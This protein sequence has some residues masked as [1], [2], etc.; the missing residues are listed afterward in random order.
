[1]QFTKHKSLILL[2]SLFIS[3]VYMRAQ[4]VSE[5][6]ASEQGAASAEASGTSDREWAKRTSKINVY[7][8]KMSDLTKKIKNLILQKNANQKVVDEKGQPVDALKSMAALHAELKKTV[9]DYNKEKAELKYRYP[10]EGALI[11]RR[12]L[13]LR[14]QTLQQIENE[15]GIDAELTKTK[16]KI[17]KKYSSF[18]GHELKVQ[19][20]APELPEATLKE[21][22]PQEE[23]PKKLKLTK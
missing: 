8:T 17:D 13:P 7:E 21:K 19:A 18:T 16:K 10:E 9:A 5:P 15:I 22:D 20:P 1:M 2:T 14:P 4:A 23:S 3:L 6:A 11:E 12:Y